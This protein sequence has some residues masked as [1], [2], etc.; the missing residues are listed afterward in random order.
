LKPITRSS[1]HCFDLSYK[2][3][4]HVFT[5]VTHVSPF[6]SGISNYGEEKMLSKLSRPRLFQ[7]FR[8]AQAASY[9][10]IFYIIKEA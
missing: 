4:N 9:K 5:F 1:P 8:P 10:N 3:Y 2:E 7:R 6:I